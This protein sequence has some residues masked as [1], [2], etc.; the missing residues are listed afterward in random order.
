MK[1]SNRL[2]AIAD[3]VPEG[4][5][6]ADIGTDHGYLPVWLLKNRIVPFAIAADLRE[7]PL[8]TAI[9]TAKRYGVEDKVSFRL[10]DGLVGINPD[11]VDTVSIAGMGGE[12]IAGILSAALWTRDKNIQLLLQPQ[13]AFYDL[14]SFL[15]ENGFRVIREKIIREGNRLY[16]VLEVR[17]GQED[18][19]SAGALWAGKNTNDPLRGDFLD[20][21]IRVLNKALSGMR[22]AADGNGEEAARM[23][24]AIA[25]LIEMKKEWAAWQL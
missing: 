8:N 21:L 12:T 4:A 9:Q 2:R 18:T 25:D 5:R 19:L 6:F 16:T 11:E 10:C 3:W 1:L 15:Y 13:S 23:E 24:A 14:R 20:W 7:S 22:Q 17:A